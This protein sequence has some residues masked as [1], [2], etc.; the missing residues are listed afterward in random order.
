MV[1]CKSTGVGKKK[2][3]KQDSQSSG[4]HEEVGAT[5]QGAK[6]IWEMPSPFTKN[7]S[8]LSYHFYKFEYLSTAGMPLI[9]VKIRLFK[10]E[11]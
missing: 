11:N 7:P 10:Y 2:V 1:N 3:V 6:R 4:K 9:K 5:N 8:A